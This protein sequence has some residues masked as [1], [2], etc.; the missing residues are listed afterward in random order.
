MENQSMNFSFIQTTGTSAKKKTKIQNNHENLSEIILNMT[1]EIRNPLSAIQ[2]FASLQYEELNSKKQDTS[3]VMDIMAGVNKINNVITNLLYYACLPEPKFER[4]KL[5]EV[6]D[7]TLLFTSFAL[8]LSNINISITDN[9]DDL[10][11]RGD[12]EQIKQCFMN[13]ILNSLKNLPDGGKI[14]INSKAKSLNEK[15]TWICVEFSDSRSTKN[16]NS[17]ADTGLPI[18]QKIIS[19][20]NGKIKITESSNF[21]FNIYLPSEVLEKEDEKGEKICLHDKH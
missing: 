3:F 16:K 12:R 8:K 7:E 5:K 13:L 21:K 17:T 4:I 15:K 18:T 11:I 20:H 2:L 19:K 1:H 6:I 10:W 14:K 9:E